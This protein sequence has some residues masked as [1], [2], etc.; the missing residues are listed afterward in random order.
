MDNKTATDTR[1]ECVGT[2]KKWIEQNKRTLHKT[3]YKRFDDDLVIYYTPKGRILTKP[4]MPPKSLKST[5]GRNVIDCIHYEG[6]AIMNA[7]IDA[8]INAYVTTIANFDTST[9]PDPTKPLSFFLGLN[10]F[11]INKST[12]EVILL[13]TIEPEDKF[14]L[15]DEVKTF[16]PENIKSFD[17]KPVELI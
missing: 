7:D 14:L 17:G 4:A 11:A 5:Y 12:N 15:F 13:N 1:D 3:G 8:Y 2:Y 6:P 10:G 16:A 9:N